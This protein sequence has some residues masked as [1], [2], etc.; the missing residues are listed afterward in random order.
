MALG[1]SAGR[2]IPQTKCA[3]FGDDAKTVYNT[4][5]IHFVFFAS[6]GAHFGFFSAQREHGKMDAIRAICLLCVITT[7]KTNN[8]RYDFQVLEKRGERN[9][10]LCFIRIIIKD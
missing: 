1:G 5:G 7:K 3:Q 9:T 6:G 8:T 2:K 4:S 10:S